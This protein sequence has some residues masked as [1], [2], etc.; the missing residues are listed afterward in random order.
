M[1]AQKYNLRK[2]QRKNSAMA[3]SSNQEKE[4]TPEKGDVVSWKWSG[5]QPSGR[6]IDVNVGET[7]ITTEK[8]HTVARHGTDADPAVEIKS[9]TTGSTVLK[10]A[11]EI[12][13][14]QKKTTDE[15]SGGEKRPNSEESSPSKKRKTGKQ[16]DEAGLEEEN[17]FDEEGESEGLA[18]EDEGEGLANEDMNE[19]ELE[20]TLEKGLAEK[21]KGETDLKEKIE[22]KALADPDKELVMEHADE[23][24]KKDMKESVARRTRSKDEPE[25]S[26]NEEQIAKDIF[27][28]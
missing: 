1:I 22:G 6:V 9:D 13:V 26:L 21:G 28:S 25:G 19:A 24:T 8:G 18:K 20:D 14:E 16:D 7:Q 15:S 17:E 10:K 23:L 11:S 27:E 3:R 5:G 2:N 4:S 12:R